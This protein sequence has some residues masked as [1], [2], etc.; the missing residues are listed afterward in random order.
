MTPA[1][2]AAIER[3]TAGL[4]EIHVAQFNL[5]VAAYDAAGAMR[6]F[7]AALQATEDRI[8]AREAVEVAQHPDLAELNVR[9]DGYYDPPVS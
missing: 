9:L 1:E 5:F 7:A 3:C 6:D 4:R 2:R 8:A